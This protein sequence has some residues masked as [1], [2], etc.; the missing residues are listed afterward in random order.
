MDLGHDFDRMMEFALD[1]A[2]AIDTKVVKRGSKQYDS[3]LQAAMQVA[4]EIK[5]RHAGAKFLLQRQLAA[6][7]I[8]M[9]FQRSLQ[10]AMSNAPGDRVFGGLSEDINSFVGEPDLIVIDTDGKV[11]IY[12]FKT[13]G[14]E[15][16]VE[17]HPEYKLQIAC[18]AQMLKQYGIE[19][20]N[21]ELIPVKVNYVDSNP[22]I[23]EENISEKN[24]FEVQSFSTLLNGD[25]V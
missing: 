7:E 17:N 19:I 16:T 23:G 21:V 20:R 24:G 13:S 10:L 22:D 12:D 8:S 18:Y 2:S 15:V 14:R 9:A 11:S 4:K 6:K 25:S 5:K 3:M 1:Q